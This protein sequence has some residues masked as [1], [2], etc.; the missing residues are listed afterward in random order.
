MVLYSLLE[1]IPLN[2]LVWKAWIDTILGDIDARACI[3]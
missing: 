3:P 1:N 2:Q